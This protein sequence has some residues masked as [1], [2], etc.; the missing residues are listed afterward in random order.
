MYRAH[1]PGAPLVVACIYTRI[2]GFDR[3]TGARAWVYEASAGFSR[4]AVVG[5]RVFAGGHFRIVCLDYLTGA[6]VWSVESPVAAGTFLVDGD[7]I[8]VASSTGEVAAFSATDGRFL[9]HDPLKGWGQFAIALATP[10]NTAP[11][12]S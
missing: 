4:I 8:F 7:E 3:R 10:G 9:W 12:D 11:I 6:L 5:N 1:P 2:V